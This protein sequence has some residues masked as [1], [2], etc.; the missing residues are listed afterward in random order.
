MQASL[1]LR[2]S[3]R[4]GIRY[5]SQLVHAARPREAINA[6]EGHSFDMYD[7]VQ[8]VYSSKRNIMFL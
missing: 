1:S 5:S 3:H 8:K 2:L 4:T 6:G 7:N